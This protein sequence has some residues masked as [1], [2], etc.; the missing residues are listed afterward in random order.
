MK[1]ELWNLALRSILWTAQKYFFK[2]LNFHFFAELCPFL[3]FSYIF[4]INLTGDCRSICNGR[5]FIFCTLITIQKLLLVQKIFLAKIIFWPIFMK[6]KFWP[7]W[8]FWPS[9][10]TTQIMLELWNL[11]QS[12]ILWIPPGVFFRFL[13]FHFFC[14][15]IPLFEFFLIYSLLNWQWN[16]RSIFSDRMFIFGTLFTIQKL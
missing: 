2:F 7:F 16:C 4:S 1:L 3:S 6:F 10:L 8:Y 9:I 12:F 15:V 13:N 5:M 11:A 14:W